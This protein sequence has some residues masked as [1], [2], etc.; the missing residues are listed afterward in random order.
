LEPARELK[1]EKSYCAAWEATLAA[2]KARPFHPEAAML[3]AEIA[4]AA[5]DSVSARLCAQSAQALAPGWRAPKQFLK[6]SPKGA[7]KL[8]WLVVPESLQNTH[9][10]TR[11]SVCLIVKNEEEF[12]AQA[13]QSVGD[14][15]HQIIVVDTG[16]TDRTL[17]IARQ[18]GAEVY[19]AEWS[20]DFS[21]ARNAALEHATGDWVLIL[22]ADEELTDPASLT[23]ELR[24]ST[25]MAYRL[26]IVDAGKEDEGCN[27]VPRLFRNAPGL[28]FTGRIH[29]QV[30]PSLE[31]CRKEWGLENC[32]GAT[33]LRHHGY[34]AEQGPR[35]IAR[36]LRLLKLAV[37][38]SPTDPNLRM[39]YGLEMVRDGQLDAGLEQYLEAF[40]LLS[41][42]PAVVPEMRE[43]LLT[44]LATRLLA[45]R[46]FSEI[47]DLLES[48]LASASGLTSSMHLLF[49]LACMELKHY[50][51]GAEQMRQCVA[52]RKQRALTPINRDIHTA[53]P[54]H[55]LA[56][57]LQALGEAGAAH[58]AFQAALAEA[59]QSAPLRSDYARFL[60]SQGNPVDA[61]KLLHQAV[62]E[63]A[64]QPE[65]WRL[66]GEV[67]LSRPELFEFAADWTGEAIKCLPGDSVLRWHRAQAL[68]FNRQPAQAVALF[69]S[70]PAP[71]DA[72]HLSRLATCRWLADE[73]ASPLPAAL[74]PDASREFLRWYRQLL[75]IGAADFVQ[76]MHTRLKTLSPVLPSASAVLDAVLH[77][78]GQASIAA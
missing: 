12:I 22:D 38:E 23:K 9:R 21:A 72:V 62:A 59:P 71:D 61:L 42:Q 32:L 49:G 29:E 65:L 50:D 56:L 5:K 1:R 75:Q 68:L 66:G 30:F 8:D 48:P 16:S 46:R 45:A 26:P 64:D 63:K 2:L 18:H 58:Q 37:A 44:Q 20:D 77:E 10:T 19:P 47:A 74:E 40:R 60:S 31:A 6:S 14:A 4:L 27:Y 28:F 70:A 24:C 51:R 53:M 67:A 35:K 52:K 73:A 78:A 3:L 69:A 55:C 17:E 11:L 43:A 33:T 39:N 54:Q 13:L 25:V 76:Q 7:A 57:C 34:S 36:N 15:A 41:A